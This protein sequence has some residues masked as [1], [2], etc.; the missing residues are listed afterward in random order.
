MQKILFVTVGGSHQPIVTSI[1]ALEP[2]RVIFICSDGSRG[3]KPQVVGKDNPCE[4]RQNGKIIERLPNIPTQVNLGDAFDPENDIILLKS[5]DDLEECYEK[6]VAK[7]QEIK[8]QNSNAEI[9]ADYTGGTK[10]MS[11]ALGLASLDYRLIPY[12]T[13]GTRTD[14]IKI[15]RGELTSEA[16]VAQI[17]A[18]RTIEQ[19]LP[20]FLQ[21][22]NYP[23]ATTELRKLLSSV[24]L[25]SDLKQRIQDFFSC[26]SGLDAWDRFEHQEAL[27]L[28]EN[29]MNRSEIRNLGIFLKK[30]IYSRSQID[31]DFDSTYGAKGHGYEIVQDLLLNA[32][33]RATQERY[34]DAV[35][36][37]YRAIELFGQIR[38][39]HTYEIK[40]GDVDLAKI[41]EPL[42]QKYEKFRSDQNQKIQIGLAMSYELLGDLSDPI[43]EL[44]AN[45]K[46]LI[47]D[48]LNVRNNSLFAHGFKPIN[49]EEYQKFSDVIG[50]F[51]VEG[52]K[53][54]T[55]K[56]QP[57]DS[58][59]FP[60][61]LSI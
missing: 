56:E 40:T 17:K 8:A 37:L 26:C 47:M 44:Y 28:L 2:D 10:T 55:K 30:V 53:L 21:Q 33:R 18:Q 24:A 48:A 46:N 13:T 32:Q 11:V 27:A 38:L 7:I 52:I 14:I 25:T 45:Q 23:A 35:G 58:L 34:D 50:G 5:P 61:C 15:N 20:L 12:L 60:S 16:G 36:R 3:S 29:Y 41:P 4:I 57:L 59:Q 19:F 51:I 43:N 31:S 22:Y 39:L 42:K 9:K 54:V 6:I 1:K 49:Q